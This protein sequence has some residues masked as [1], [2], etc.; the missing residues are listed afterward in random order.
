MNVEQTLTDE[1]DAVARSF[2]APPPPATRRLVDQAQRS[3][4]RVRL[5]LATTL[6]AAAAVIAAIVAG[7]QLGRP[8]AAPS[9]THPTPTRVDGQLP[10]GAPPRLPYVLHQHLYVDGKAQPG[11]WSGV[12]TAGHTTL[13]F[14]GGHDGNDGQPV[15]FHDGVAV[16][17]LP[18]RGVDAQSVRLS[19]LGTKVA[20]TEYDNDSAHLVVR[21]METGR[22]LGRLSVDRETFAHDGAENE[23]WENV[24]SVAD[25]GTVTYG[26]VVVVHTWKPGSAPVDHDPVGYQQTPEGYPHRAN[27]VVESPDAAWGAWQ[28]DRHGD[29]DPPTGDDG[30]L[31]F[32]GVTVQR[33]GQPGS[34]FT[35]AMP[36]G[37]TEVRQLV[38]ETPA[39]ILVLVVGA[40]LDGL[41]EELVRCDVVKRTCEH[42]STPEDR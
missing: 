34:R 38:W 36:D 9:P 5:R 33:P 39:D 20:W 37:T 10:T 32:D 18:A 25:D 2:E 7:T 17:P 31:V 6:V 8:N 27:L 26:S 30:A 3:R 42:A 13:A 41:P 23:G 15:L 16:A 14:T 22:E 1:L 4:R 28:T 12:T 21:D 19:P 29:P 11:L 35:F 40:V 24:Q